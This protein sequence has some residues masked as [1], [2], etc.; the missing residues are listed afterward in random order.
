MIWSLEAVPPHLQMLF[1]SR[2]CNR[3]CHAGSFPACHENKPASAGTRLPSLLFFQSQD[4]CLILA[5]HCQFVKKGKRNT[6]ICLLIASFPTT[7]GGPVGAPKFWRR[8][9]HNGASQHKAWHKIFQQR[10]SRSALFGTAPSHT[11]T[12]LLRH[13]VSLARDEIL[14]PTYRCSHLCSHRNQ[15]TGWRN[16]W[17]NIHV[18]TM[19]S[20]TWNKVILR[21]RECYRR[22]RA[23]TRLRC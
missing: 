22:R 5:K 4:I 15:Q 10:W 11:T 8:E 12:L 2:N 1:Y 21:G 7:E 23:Q 9:R 3:N 18:A 14:L 16:C 13:R 20:D 19:T 17:D 6:I